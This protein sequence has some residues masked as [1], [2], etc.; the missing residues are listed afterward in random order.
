[1][2]S[3]KVGFKTIDE[4]I[5]AFFEDIRD[6]LEGLRATIKASAHFFRTARYSMLLNSLPSGIDMKDS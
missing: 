1:M 5:A 4:Y 2:E 3:R 6:T